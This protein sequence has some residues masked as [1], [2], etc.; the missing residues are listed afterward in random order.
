MSL[1]VQN[2]FLQY[3]IWN[4]QQIKCLKRIKK[5]SRENYK[6][7]IRKRYK[8]NNRKCSK[9]KKESLLFCCQNSQNAKENRC[10]FHYLKNGLS[11]S[12]FFPFFLMIVGAI[13]EESNVTIF[14][15][16]VACHFHPF[17]KTYNGM[18]VS[19]YCHTISNVAWC[20][21]RPTHNQ[22]VLGPSPTRS[23]CVKFKS[24][25]MFRVV[26]SSQLPVK[27]ATFL[28]SIGRLLISLWVAFFKKIYVDWPLTFPT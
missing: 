2:K 15:G 28:G 6:T 20:S 12:Q 17:N 19:F 7:I 1:S 8:E 26:K 11:L 10:R 18:E 16:N 13:W 22:E 21:V 3:S 24:T 5:L 23:S 9:M 27:I 4:L 14:P 25:P